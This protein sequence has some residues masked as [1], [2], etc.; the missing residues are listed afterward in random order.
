[1]SRVRFEQATTLAEM[2]AA[3]DW[4]YD[5]SDARG[6]WA[7]GDHERRVLIARMVEEARKSPERRLE[8]INLWHHYC[9]KRDGVLMFACPLS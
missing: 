7:R 3:H 5:F 1:M 9:P 4:T 2:M 6:V 8:V